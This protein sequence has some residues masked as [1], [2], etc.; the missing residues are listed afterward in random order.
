MDAGMGRSRAAAGWIAAAVALVVVVGVVYLRPSLRVAS[1]PAPA[2]QA[3]TLQVGTGQAVVTGA[4]FRDARHG[5]VSILEGTPGTLAYRP[6]TFLTSDG[7]TTWTRGFGSDQ[8][9]VLGSP[10]GPSALLRLSA[11]VRGST[12]SFDLGRTWRTLP[13]LV[14]GTSLGSAPI[15]VDGQHGWWLVQLRSFDQVSG[16][17][18]LLRTVDG[19]RTWERITLSG[20]PDSYRT[21]PLVF[22]DTRRGVLAAQRA[23]GAWSLLATD[24]GGASWHEAATLGAPLPGTRLFAVT[25]LRDGA[26][27][28]VWAE[29]LPADQILDN[30]GGGVVL[31]GPNPHM[32]LHPYLLASD[33]GGATWGSPV[34][35]PQ[36]DEKYEGVPVLDGRGR[37]LVLEGRRLWVSEDDGATWSARLV[38][39]PPDLEPAVLLPPAGDG[40]LLAIAASPTSA[41]GARSLSALLRSTDG[42]VH[43]EPMRLPR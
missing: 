36:L 1:A 27:L 29:A 19:G 24:D 28:I 14:T 21:G 20:I 17:S 12:F 7:G 38:Q 11:S 18:Q 9:A 25:L 35:A 22:A 4:V 31:T 5:A 34:A 39:A 37:L 40:T 26:R 33:D 16:P 30:P 13:D 3:A 6:A 41:V 10:S 43:W 42:G 8:V 23:D 32:E 15:F 2:E